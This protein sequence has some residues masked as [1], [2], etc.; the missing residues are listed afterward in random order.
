MA[1]S[2]GCWARITLVEDDAVVDEDAADEP[3]MVLVP[4]MVLPLVLLFIPPEPLLP[5]LLPRP[6]VPLPLPRPV[7]LL[8]PPAPPDP[9][10]DPPSIIPCCI[11]N[12]EDNVEYGRVWI[13]LVDG[14]NASRES[15]EMVVTEVEIGIGIVTLKM[16]L[17][18]MEL[19]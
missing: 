4:E 16:R 8:F 17:V 14:V 1:L 2:V 12:D 10:P 5:L 7:L 3:E 11:E 13:P 18:E 19:E 15:T 9:I 6:P